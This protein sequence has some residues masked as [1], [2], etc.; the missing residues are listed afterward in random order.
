M[1]IELFHPTNLRSVLYFFVRQNR[2]EKMKIL[3]GLPVEHTVY[4]GHYK[5]RHNI[6]LKTT[7]IWNQYVSDF[8]AV[9]LSRFFIGIADFIQTP[10]QLLL[11]GYRQHK[12]VIHNTF[13]ILRSGA[14]LNTMLDFC[15]PS[16]HPLLLLVWTIL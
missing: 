6:R 11:N 3:F 8:P 16:S 14:N 5:V 15:S 10:I 13:L 2:R 4:C 9:N 1:R 7:E 12:L